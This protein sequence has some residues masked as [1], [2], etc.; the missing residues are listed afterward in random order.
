[1]KKV[2]KFLKL[3]AMDIGRLVSVI[4]VI[5]FRVRRLDTEGKAYRK[6]LK[7]GVLIAANHLNF[8]DPLVV[9]CTFWYR[10]VFFL[11]AEALMKNKLVAALL[12]GIGCI[13]IDRNISDVEAIGKS[14]RL[15]KAGKCLVMFPQGGITKGLDSIKAGAALIALQSGVSIL[16]MYSAPRRHWW[17]RRVAV[18]GEMID[19]KTLVKG[20]IPSLQ[21]LSHISDT[22]LSEM[23]KCKSTFEGVMK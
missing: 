12:K 10:R 19:P 5:A 3:L 13:K 9:G 7:G 2:K 6:K 11:A 21:D 20:K 17:Q 4:F 8:V 16:P 18:I 14:V 22:L 1:M 23:E 15:L